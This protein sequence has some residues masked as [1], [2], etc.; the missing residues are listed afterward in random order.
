MSKKK[1]GFQPLEAGL[2]DATEHQKAVVMSTISGRLGLP[3]FKTVETTKEKDEAVQALRKWITGVPNQMNDLARRFWECV[4][5]DE[6]HCSI[7]HVEW[8]EIGEAIHDLLNPGVQIAKQAAHEAYVLAMIQHM[9]TKRWAI[10][11]LLNGKLK[12]TDVAFSGGLINLEVVKE[13][14]DETNMT[15]TMFRLLNRTYQVTGKNARSIASLLTSKVEQTNEE[16]RDNFRERVNALLNQ[17]TPGLTLEKVKNGESGKLGFSVRDTNRETRDGGVLL[18]HSDGEKICVL[19]AAG[20]FQRRT[21]EIRTNGRTLLVESLSWDD[22][23]Q[24]K[25]MEYGIYKDLRF[26]WSVIKRSEQSNTEIELRQES[27][28]AFQK[29]CDAERATFAA[30]ATVSPADWLL[31]KMPGTALISMSG[32]WIVKYGEKE[33]PYWYVSFLAERTAD[34]K[35]RIVEFPERLKNLF[36]SPNLTELT[37]PGDTSGNLAYPPSAMLRKAYA[38]ELNR[39]RLASE[40]DKT[41]KSE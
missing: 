2:K 15:D 38:I 4:N 16:A 3:V 26:L 30:K 27:R 33:T 35:V 39:S 24:P 1:P 36:Q 6:A 32:P 22:F 7:H 34:G 40:T 13:V 21:N 25:M 9:P 11:A 19:D 10:L 8:T 18:I 5:G 14:S 23:R 28:Q 20:H 12:P 41:V 37:E 17:T 31:K 29:A